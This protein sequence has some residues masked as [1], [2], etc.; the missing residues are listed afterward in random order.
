MQY[1]ILIVQFKKIENFVF[2]KLCIFLILFS[3]YCYA[4]GV[5]FN[6][7][8]KRQNFLQISFVFDIVV[9]VTNVCHTMFHWHIT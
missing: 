7:K 3:Y 2:A 9:F 6:G 4:V 5:C 1:P 8:E